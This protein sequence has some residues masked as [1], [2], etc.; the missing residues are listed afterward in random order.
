MQLAG[1]IYERRNRKNIDEFVVALQIDIHF[2]KDI[3]ISRIRETLS[4]IYKTLN[5]NI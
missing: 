1:E 3:N 4:K 5:K 2:W